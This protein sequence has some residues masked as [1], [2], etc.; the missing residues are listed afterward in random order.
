MLKQ[1]TKM[2]K[3]VY[4][5][6]LFGRECR[7]SLVHSPFSIKYPI[8]KWVK[9]KLK[10]SKLMVFSSRQAALKVETCYTIVPCHIK[11]SK[12]QSNQVLDVSSFLPKKNL[13]FF[14]EM[15]AKQDSRIRSKAFYLRKSSFA[16][17]TDMST[18]H[19]LAGTIFADEVFCLA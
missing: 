12:V 15:V 14:W 4:Y 16:F 13:T 10:G 6:I 8:Q 18:R 2:K 11:R 3:K 5:K 1:G 9:P 7:E 19:K 17:G